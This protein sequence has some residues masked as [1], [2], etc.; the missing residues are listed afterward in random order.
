M[1]G[2]ER[3]KQL[4][5]ILSASS[6]PVSGGRLSQELHVSRQVIVQDISAL[7]AGGA[8]IFST[9]RGYLLQEEKKHTRVFKVFHTTDQVEKELSLIIDAG[10]IVR[11]V[12]VYHKVYGILK[13][14]MNLKSRR[15]LS[16]Y[17]EQLSSGV[18]SLLMN[19]TSGYHYHTVE[20]ESEEILDEIQEELRTQQFLARLQDYEP[21]DFWEKTR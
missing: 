14:D 21:V 13:A 19:I 3:R 12:F 4:L 2:E 16:A 7:R 18:S 1:K 8:S 9:N 20:A 11:N 6:G 15:D 17:M 5:N 10:G